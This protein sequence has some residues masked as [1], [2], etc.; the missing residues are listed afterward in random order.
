MKAPNRIVPLALQ[1]HRLL[2][3]FLIQYRNVLFSE[4]Q[5]PD[6]CDELIIK[7]QNNRHNWFR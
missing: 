7:L 6:I 5:H 4:R 1:E 2:M 3:S